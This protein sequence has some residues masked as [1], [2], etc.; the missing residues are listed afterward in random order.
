MVLYLVSDLH[1]YPEPAP[2]PGREAFFSFLSDLGRIDSPGALWLLG[3]LFDFWFEYGTV[4]QAGHERLLSL[5]R[6]LSDS[7]WELHFLP[8]NHDFPAGKLFSAST[9][10][11]V[12]PAGPV[13]LDHGGRRLCF[14]HGDGLGTGD[15]AYRAIKP[16]IRS[17]AARFLFSLIHPDLGM[18]L[19][20][21]FSGTSRRI[22]RRDLDH[23]P[24]GL[25]KW[26]AGVL[27]AGADIVVTGHSHMGRITAMKGGLHV[28][29]GDWLTRMSYCILPEDSAS[30]PLLLTYSPREG[31][32][33]GTKPAE[34]GT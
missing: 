17:R 13:V 22:L 3:D 19:A 4:V 18:R 1:H 21:L 2:H 6:N 26:A 31:I 11:R 30:E 12:H 24:A 15:L 27:S 32:P 29:I 9:G 23:V 5:L 16:V 8:G 25:E 20:G 10:A 28:S 34:G 14:A 7:G 33:G